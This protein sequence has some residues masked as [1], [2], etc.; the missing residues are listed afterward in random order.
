[1]IH[2]WLQVFCKARQVGRSSSA[3]AKG[4]DPQ[5]VLLQGPD[6]SL[7]AAIGLWPI[8]RSD[9]GRAD[10]ALRPAYEDR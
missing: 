1:M 5:Q 7:G 3:V 9:V 4:T 2:L 8:P 10:R 6:G